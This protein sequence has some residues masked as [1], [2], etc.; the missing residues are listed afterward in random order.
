VDNSTADRSKVVVRVIQEDVR[1]GDNISVYLDTRRRDRGP[2]YRLAARFGSEYTLARLETWTRATRFLDCRDN[3]TL[4]ESSSTD[5]T[6]VVLPRKCL[7]GPGRVRAAVF[8]ERDSG[9]GSHD[10]AKAR[11]TW[12]KWVRR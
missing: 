5:R 11:R 9:A 4:N 2:E 7:G 8:V 6:R 1:D 12:L 10:W 3:I